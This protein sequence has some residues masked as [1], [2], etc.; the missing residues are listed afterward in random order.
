MCPAGPT[1]PVFIF[2]SALL[3]RQYPVNTSLKPSPIPLTVRDTASQFAKTVEGVWKMKWKN[4]E[5]E[6]LS[7]L[8][9]MGIPGLNI[10]SACPCGCPDLGEQPNVSTSSETAL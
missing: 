10:P 5:K 9:V 2:T 4:C 3:Q 8:A 6:V 7:R 1:A